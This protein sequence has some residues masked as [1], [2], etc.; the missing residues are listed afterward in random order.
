M[1]DALFAKDPAAWQQWC[2]EMGVDADHD[3]AVC[4]PNIPQ[5]TWEPLTKILPPPAIQRYLDSGDTLTNHTI[6]M[7]EMAMER[8][9]GVEYPWYINAERAGSEDNQ[10]LSTTCFRL[11]KEQSSQEFAQ[12]IGAA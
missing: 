10:T 1:L 6:D 4:L 8:D 3:L 7:M 11:M 2:K 12:S 9:L 5:E